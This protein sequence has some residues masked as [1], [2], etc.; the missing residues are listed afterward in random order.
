MK[1]MAI[2]EIR[3]LSLFKISHFAIYIMFSLRSGTLKAISLVYENSKTDGRRYFF[4]FPM[5]MKFM[6]TQN[7][8]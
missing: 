2:T 6:T 5:K 3:R 1:N 7:G 4:F 8:K